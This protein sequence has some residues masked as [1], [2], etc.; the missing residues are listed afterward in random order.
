MIHTSPRLFIV[1]DTHLIK[2][3]LL[4]LLTSK[5]ASPATID[6]NQK[7]RDNPSLLPL[8][9][10]PIPGPTDFFPLNLSQLYSHLV[11]ST[12]LPLLFLRYICPHLHFCLT[13]S[14]INSVAEWSNPQIWHSCPVWNPSMA[15]CCLQSKIQ[16]PHYSIIGSPSPA[17]SG[18]YNLIFITFPIKGL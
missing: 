12:P 15:P 8:L 2:F 14:I 4:P 1:P 17:T 10:Q 3:N 5:L 16:T 18:Y 9:T 7:N 6:P 11:V 13:Q